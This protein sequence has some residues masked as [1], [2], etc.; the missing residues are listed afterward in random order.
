MPLIR[1]FESPFLQTRGWS[2]R[3]GLLTHFHTHTAHTAGSC[4]LTEE[5]IET[6]SVVWTFY[7]PQVAVF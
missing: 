3:S 4:K 5:A 1:A 2:A 7:F 6:K